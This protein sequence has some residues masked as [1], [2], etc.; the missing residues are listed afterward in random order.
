MSSVG[1]VVAQLREVIE[2]LDR[3]VVA[4]GRV[5]ADA[6]QAQSYFAEVG[7][8][9]DHPR[10]RQAVGESRTAGEKAGKVARLLAEAGS[11]LAA[12]V[13]VIAP[14]SAPSRDRATDSLPTGDQL[15]REAEDKGN[16]ADRFIRRHVKKADQTEG[17]LQNAEAVATEGLKKLVKI[18]KSQPGSTGTHAPAPQPPPIDRPQ[19][20]HPGTA[21]VIAAG[22]AAVGVRRI[23]IKIKDRRER[24]TRGSQT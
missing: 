12:Y 17:N 18:Y 15:V 20:E 9:T 2:R 13:N 14:G 19:V 10:I 6:V 1:E 5:Q 3:S 7:Q 24:K 23:W 22:A 11:H 16:N 8:G 21:M 4:A